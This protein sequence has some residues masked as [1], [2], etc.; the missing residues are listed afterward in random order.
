MYDCISETFKS[1]GNP[2]KKGIEYRVG[3][4]AVVALHRQK[5]VAPNG[6]DLL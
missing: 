3:E 5:C 6:N 4:D 2:W 1:S